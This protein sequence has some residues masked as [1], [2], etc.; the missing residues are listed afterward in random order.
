MNEWM[1]DCLKPELSVH[2]SDCYFVVQRLLFGIGVLTSQL[3]C[4]TFTQL[5]V[6]RVLVCVLTCLSLNEYWLIDWLQNR[7][8]MESRNLFSG[9]LSIGITP[10]FSIPAI[11]PVSHFPL[12]HFQSPNCFKRTRIEMGSAQPPLTSSV[13]FPW[14]WLL[15]CKKV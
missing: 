9:R 11:L 3:R 4:Y 10:A 12:L 14:I 8:S 15:K 1:N 6:I 13:H 5:Y 7:Q 2:L